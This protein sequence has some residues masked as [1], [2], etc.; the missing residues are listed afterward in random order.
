MVT[1]ERNFYGLKPVVEAKNPNGAGVELAVANALATA[2][3]LDPSDV[4]VISVDG[5]YLKS[6]ISTGGQIERA[7]EVARSVHRVMQ[8]VNEL[9]VVTGIG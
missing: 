9:Q 2:G 3:G 8:V 7:S 5:A 4:V 1:H 6:S